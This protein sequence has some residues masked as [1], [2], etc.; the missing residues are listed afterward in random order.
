MG[1]VGLYSWRKSRS[2]CSI[3]RLAQADNF[4]VF[5]NQLVTNLLNFGPS[6]VPTIT[7]VGFL[8]SY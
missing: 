6:S 2:E 8:E 5:S 3:S 7:P 4:S 1:T